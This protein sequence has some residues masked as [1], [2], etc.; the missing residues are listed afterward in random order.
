MDVVWG[1]ARICIRFRRPGIDSEVSI[2]P[3]Y[4]A[5]RAGTTNSVVAPARQTGI[6]FLGSLKGLQ[7]R[8]QV[9]QSRGG[10][11]A[12]NLSG[13]DVRSDR[14]GRLV[15]LDDRVAVLHG[16][17]SIFY[18]AHRILHGLLCSIPERVE[19][20]FLIVSYYYEKSS[21]EASMFGGGGAQRPVLRVYKLK[22]RARAV[23]R[24]VARPK[25]TYN[26]F[27]TSCTW[28]QG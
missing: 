14:Q 13:R 15:Y 9:R 3:A 21:S 17:K 22:R 2:P 11:A 25:Q 26:K 4:A 7:I 23:H 12:A 19:H 18:L 10:E 1:R 20:C 6:R 24:R 5:L 16:Y 28:N 27:N 8:A